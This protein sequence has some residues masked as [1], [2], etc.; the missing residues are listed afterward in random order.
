[1]KTGVHT[2]LPSPKN[3]YEQPFLVCS[4]SLYQARGSYAPAA[5]VPP[6]QARPEGIDVLEHGPRYLHGG[7]DEAPKAVPRQRKIGPQLS[8]LRIFVVADV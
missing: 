4:R 6:V 7:S 2:Q 3:S 5:G 8:V 1:M